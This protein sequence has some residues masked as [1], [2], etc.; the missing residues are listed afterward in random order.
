MNSGILLAAIF[1]GLCVSV[2]WGWALLALA[3]LIAWATWS[4]RRDC[5]KIESEANGWCPVLQQETEAEHGA[6]KH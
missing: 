4:A 3:L 1:F 2:G 6:Q 5:R